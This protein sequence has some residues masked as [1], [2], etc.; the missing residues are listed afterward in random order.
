[1]L[2]LP[3]G[4]QSKKCPLEKSL[5]EKGVAVGSGTR[6]KIARIEK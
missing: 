2:V 3:G 5:S 1:M 4:S 6:K